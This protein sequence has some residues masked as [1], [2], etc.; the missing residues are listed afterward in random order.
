MKKLFFLTFVIFLTLITNVF[1]QNNELKSP[2]KEQMISMTD[3]I[4]L[5]IKKEKDTYRKITSKTDSVLNS[6]NQPDNITECVF[7]KDKEILI[8]QIIDTYKKVITDYYINNGKLIYVETK[9]NDNTIDKTY[10]HLSLG[11]I[12]AIYKNEKEE[13]Y[14]QEE[15]IKIGIAN[16]EEIEKLLK[17]YRK[18]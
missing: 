4:V 5:E 1:G 11:Y 3:K 9:Y 16:Q 8:V 7:K 17:K 6:K 18:K 12:N 2:S 14:T 13:K 15:K 10:Y